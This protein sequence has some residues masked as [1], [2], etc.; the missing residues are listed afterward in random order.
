MPQLSG[1]TGSGAADEDRC[2]VCHNVPERL[3]EYENTTLLHEVHL[4][5]RN[6]ECQLCHRP[7]D[8]KI[9][10]LSEKLELNCE[11]CHQGSHEAQQNM[12][13]GTGAHGTSEDPSSMFL[14]RVTCQSCHRLPQEMVGHEQV[15]VAGE[16]TCLSCHGIRYANILPGWQ[17]ETQRKLELVGSVVDA[18]ARAN[19]S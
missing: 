11:S 9:V 7:I 12:F 14:A 2:Y 19:T 10:S 16:A 15:K 1:S 6:I 5:E 17:A 13:S 3:A 4:T 8:H 18:A